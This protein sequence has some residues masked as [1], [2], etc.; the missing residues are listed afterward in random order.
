MWGYDFATAPNDPHTVY[1]ADG[2]FSAGAIYRSTDAGA[3]WSTYL[4]GYVVRSVAVDPTSPNDVYFWS[5]FG[6]PVYHA[7]QNGTQ[8]VAASG[9]IDGGAT[10]LIS[11]SGPAP[12]LLMAG[13]TG[14]YELAFPRPN[15]NIVRSG[16]SV[17]L[18]WT[19]STY[20]LQAAPNTTG[21]YTNIPGATSPFT[22]SLLS[23]RR[24]FRL[25]K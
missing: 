24:F 11:V 23:S 19:N 13:T 5:I 10:Q 12:R 7:S 8:V 16:N 14:A 4:T 17:V 25:A 3:T 21:A 2:A 18:S 15:L 22:N 9:G 1:V 6:T 20:T